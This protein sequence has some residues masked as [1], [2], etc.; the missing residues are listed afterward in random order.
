MATPYQN[1]LQQG[2][3]QATER[4][5]DALSAILGTTTDAELSAYLGVQS[6][7]VSQWRA[8]TA[9]PQRTALKTIAGR[10]ASGFVEPIAEIEPVAPSRHGGGWRVDGDAM[11]RARW[12]QRLENMRGFY[13]FYDSMGRVTYVGQAKSNL[14]VE[15]E[16]RLGQSLRHSVYT[17]VPPAP[18]LVGTQFQQGD[19][20]KFLSAYRTRTG[21]AAHNMEAIL[22]RAVANSTQNRKLAKIKLGTREV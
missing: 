1:G 6:A 18:K 7:S 16:Q 10:L 14:Y 22:I 17:R 9:A 19:V 5:L 2:K 12:R 15:I 20:A 21:E 8:G 3:R 11:R 13:L 4:L